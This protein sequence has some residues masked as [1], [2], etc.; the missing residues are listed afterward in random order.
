MSLSIENGNMQMSWR[1]SSYK[2]NVFAR[3]FLLKKSMLLFDEIADN[4]LDE[5]FKLCLPLLH[6]VNVFK[7][8]LKV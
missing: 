1:G 5:L 3:A 8:V 7:F 4:L 2:I 6:S